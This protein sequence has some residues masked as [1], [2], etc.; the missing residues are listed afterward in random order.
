MPSL[1][2]HM[3]AVTLHRSVCTAAHH[4]KGSAASQAASMTY[5]DSQPVIAG[6]HSPDPA[7]AG[8]AGRGR[9]PERSGS[10]GAEALLGSSQDTGRLAEPEGGQGCCTGCSEEEK[11]Q[12]GEKG[13]HWCCCW[14]G[15]A[16]EGC[17][18]K[19][20]AE[21]ACHQWQEVSCHVTVETSEC[22]AVWRAGQHGHTMARQRPRILPLQRRCLRG[23]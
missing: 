23:Q 12:E 15:S 18:C 3:G 10:P 6:A 1:H 19:A 9:V 16:Q 2:L 5:A 7:G 13:R 14:Q 21:E 11:A 4:H 17:C 22:L 20:S 8:P